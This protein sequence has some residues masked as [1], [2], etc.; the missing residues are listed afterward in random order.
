MIK[1]Y[2]KTALRN[3]IR[4]KV[5]T[6]INVS[7]LAVGIA[8]CLLIFLVVR[9]ELNYDK[10]QPAYDRIYHIV[11][12][13][14]HP[15]GVDYTAGIPYPALEALRSD[16]PHI[17]TGALFS[18]Y[19]SQVTIPDPTHK[20]FGK[21]FIEPGGLFFADP[22][23]FEIF[24]YTWLSGDPKILAEPNTVVLSKASA[25]K[26][27]GGWKKAIG[28]TILI[29]NAI[30]LKVNGIMEDVP[31]NSD[32][33]I[34][35]AG[36]FIT[37][38]NNRRYGYTT[39]WG[40]TTSNFQVH[41]LLPKE[42]SAAQVNKQLEK[43]ASKYYKND[44]PTKR[45][46]FLRPL[47]T[48]HF[49]TVVGNLGDHTISKSVLI[50]LSLIA[51]FIIIMACINF[52]NL[53]TAQAVNRSKEVGVRKVMGSNRSQLFWQMM[54][55]T[56]FV[57][58]I[59]AMMGCLLAGLALPYIK[60]IISIHEPLSF[61]N[62]NALVFLGLIILIT[63][64]LSG[65]YPSLILSGFKPAMAL[66]N[67]VSSA[68]IG[69]ISLRRALVV[70]QFSISQ[71]LI[72]G[73]LVAVTQMNF[74]RNADLGFNKE[75][76]LVLGS[77]RDTYVLERNA[78]FKLNLLSLP[79]VKSVSFGSDAPSSDNNSSTNF[80]FDHHSDEIFN[81]FLKFGDE[82][83]FKTFDLKFLAGKGYTKS[84]TITEVVINETLLKKLNVKDPESAIGKDIRTGSSPWKK[85]V[86]VVKDFKT[87]SL[88]EEIKPTMI[89][90]NKKKFDVVAIKLNMANLSA[91]NKSVEKLWDKFYPE[92]AYNS[93]FLDEKIQ[94]FY[95]QDMQ[96]ALLYKIFAGLAIFI[97]CLGLYGL[98][99]FMVVQKTKEVG[100]RKVLGAGISSIV[101]LFSKEFTVLILFSL[102]IA[103]PVANYFM[104]EWLDN[105]VFRITIGVNVFV[106][107]ALTS[108][109]VAWI[110]VGYKAI[111]AAIANPIKSLRTE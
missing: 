34:L 73:T 38:K 61:F 80:A 69:G 72:I 37:I 62:S 91:T 75:A 104:S 87:N 85:I 43:L 46:N 98:I 67:K 40:S 3:L 51:L 88:K 65:T 13:D 1:N 45:I 25:I 74:V 95:Q 49:D 6:L 107:S 27:F 99:S 26:Y 16:F 63:T 22:E 77:S 57:V 52:I 44:G 71:M 10:F 59:S 7:G 84:D 100:I 96:L 92:L 23:F 109:I 48:I 35:M 64:I 105:F 108:L 83:Y 111:R 14:T 89:A 60:H 21:K 31:A 24:K 55:E 17:K 11:S 76:I 94:N 110:A 2:F 50:T 12:R 29:D 106:I 32:F 102:L 19:G 78:S 97:S 47:S 28:K 66:K 58:I 70:I 54:S 15:D 82:D 53:S 9:Y 39:D 42:L 5:Y 30:D 56:M 20:T 93:F 18:T 101:Y 41:M 90:L 68:T 79:G 33:P 103:I 86:G 36:S 8:S 81:L 4:N